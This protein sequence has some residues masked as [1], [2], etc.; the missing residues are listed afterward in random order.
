MSKDYAKKFYSSKRW[1][2]CRNG[3]AAARGHLCERCLARGEYV[4]GEIVHHKQ[5]LTP[6]TIN[7]PM[8]ALNWSNLE[9]LCRKCHAD[10]HGASWDR[11]NETKRLNKAAGKR[12]FV[13]EDGKIL[14]IRPP[15]VENSTL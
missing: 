11:A 4:P 15:V 12:F 3:Y 10:E 14:P 8:V 2:D 5:H 6:S 1:Q 9:L 7:D 13:G